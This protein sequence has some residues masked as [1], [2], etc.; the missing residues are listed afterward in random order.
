VDARPDARPEGHAL[1]LWHVSEDE[2][3]ARFEPRANPDHD[4][5]EA[6]VW[7]IDSAH[8]PAYWFP[9]DVPRGTFWAVET[10]S[11]EDVER[12]LTGDRSRRVHAIESSWLPQ[13]RD[14]VVFAYRL[15]PQTFEPYGRAAGYYVSREA[16]EP[17]EVVRLEDLLARHADAGIELRIVPQL[18]PLWERVITST[19]EFSGIRLRNLAASEPGSQSEPGS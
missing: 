7:A 2:S 1:D 5:P 13:L 3:I 11:D 10:T 17:L 16:V 15:P 8:A 19:L 12:F 9:R 4:S 18:M 14:G 6:L